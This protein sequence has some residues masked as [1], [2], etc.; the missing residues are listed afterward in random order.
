[1]TLGS[2]RICFAEMFGRLWRL[3]VGPGNFVDRS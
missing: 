2:D 3:R 1:M